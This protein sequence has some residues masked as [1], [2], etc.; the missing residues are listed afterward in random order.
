MG[1]PRRIQQ[2]SE[3]ERFIEQKEEA[4]KAHKIFLELQAADDAAK[5]LALHAV[6]DADAKGET[7]DS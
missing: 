3:E 2:R 7:R 4:D 1:K 5:R 6:L